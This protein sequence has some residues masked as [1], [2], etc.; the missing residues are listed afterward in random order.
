MSDPHIVVKL[1]ETLPLGQDVH[2][3]MAARVH[4]KAR[5][6]YLDLFLGSSADVGHCP[7]DGFKDWLVV[8]AGVEQL[9]EAE[10]HAIV[11]RNLKGRYSLQMNAVSVGKQLW[12]APSLDKCMP[13]MTCFCTAKR[14]QMDRIAADRLGGNGLCPSE[15]W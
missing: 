4:V 1:S 7:A 13:E 10:Q 9:H 3:A 11:E 5:E 2:V 12:F 14:R 6:S 8:G 15:T